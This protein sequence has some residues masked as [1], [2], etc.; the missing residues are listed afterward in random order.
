MTP[1]PSTEPPPA[2]APRSAHILLAEDDPELL[3]LLA[4]ALRG[5]GYRVTE[6]TDGVELLD[7]LT[8]FALPD[9]GQVDLVISD[10]RMP[11]ISGLNILA[12]TRSMPGL[13][14]FLLITAFGNDMVHARARRL[15]AVDVLDKPFEIDDLLARVAALIGEPG[16]APPDRR[17]RLR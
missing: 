12:G 8:W 6:C 13:P 2:R 3:S 16:D 7:Q 9:D 14:P 4:W 1:L 17:R 11:G 15:G 5:H 10:V